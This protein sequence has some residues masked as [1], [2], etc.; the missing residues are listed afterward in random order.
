M[1]LSRVYLQDDLYHTS[2][3]TDLDPAVQG[4]GRGTCRLLPKHLGNFGGNPKTLRLMTN[5]W[6]TRMTIVANGM[7]IS[8]EA[9]DPEPVAPFAVP[10][11]S[12]FWKTAPA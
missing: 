5:A 10:T 2:F 8:E 4:N 3:Y 12:D 7:P 6:R 9:I 1:Y 11:L